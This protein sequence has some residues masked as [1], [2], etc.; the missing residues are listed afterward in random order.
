LDKRRARYRAEARHE[1]DTD[2][3]TPEQ[4]AEEII[5]L[6]GPGPSSGTKS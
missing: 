6:S 1:I 3:R 5:T 4:V 2:D